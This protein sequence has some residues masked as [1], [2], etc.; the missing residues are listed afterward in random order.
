MRYA[1]G[2]TS[3][4]RPRYMAEVIPT[5]QTAVDHAGVVPVTAIVRHE[6]GPETD[7]VVAAVDAPTGY[8][9]FEH[10]RNETVEG[11]LHNPWL[12]LDEL[13]AATHDDDDLLLL[14]EDD[15]VVARDAIRCLF[16]MARLAE[17]LPG[18]DLHRTF[19]CLNHRWARPLVEGVPAPEE[20]ITA[21]PKFWP[22]V[23]AISARLWAEIIRDTWDHDYSHKGWDWN[24]TER[25]I[26]IH[27]L[28]I[29]APAI[30]R[31]NHIGRYG[32][33]HT[34]E[35]NWPGGTA[36]TFDPASSI[37]Q[38]RYEEGPTP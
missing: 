21:A 26:P 30:S 7:A 8:I 25:I 15:A 11:P 16:S 23:W 4:N 17:D 31:S 2:L 27:G 34:T 35:E 28:R 5:W 19:L 32:G 13:A 3:N 36:P 14:A 37:Y 33:A 18:Y 12:V 1:L 10:R 24:F 6:P 9:R 22:S 29:L 20:V 38:F